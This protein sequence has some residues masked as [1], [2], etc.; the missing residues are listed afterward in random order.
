ML[1]FQRLLIKMVCTK[2]RGIES[3]TSQ[4]MAFRSLRMLLFATAVAALQLK[5][6]PALAEDV[7][8]IA[9]RLPEVERKCIYVVQCLFPFCG[10][11]DGCWVH[12]Q[13]LYNCTIILRYTG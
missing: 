2:S 3:Y 1:M 4:R 12:V 9:P 10:I 13:K 5:I 8:E 7:C 11:F 6:L